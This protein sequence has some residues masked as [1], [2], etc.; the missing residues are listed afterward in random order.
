MWVTNDY[1]LIKFISSNVKELFLYSPEEIY[2]MGKQAWFSRIHPDDREYVEESYNSFVKN[3]SEFNVEYRVRRKDDC[4]IWI[5]DRAV[6]TYELNSFQYRCGFITDI[7]ERKQLEKF[8]RLNESEMRNKEQ[9]F[10]SIIKHSHDGVV[11]LNEEGII[12]EWNPA[13]KNLT[14]ISAYKALGNYFWDIRYLLKPPLDQK[15]TLNRIHHSKKL[16]Q[17][18]LRT[19]ESVLFL[20]P[21]EG[22]ILHPQKGLTYIQSNIFPIKT[23]RGYMLGGIW[24][25]ITKQKNDEDKMKKKLLKFNIEDRSIYLIKEAEPVMARAVFR[26]VLKVGY[27]GIVFSR[28]PETEFR[29]ILTEECKFIWLAEST[30]EDTYVS[31]FQKIISTLHTLSSK[32]VVLIDRLDYLISVYGFEQTLR[33]IYKLREMA[34]IFGFT[35]LISIDEATISEDQIVLLEKETR[36]IRS[37]I[38]ADVPESLLEIL[39]IVYRQTSLGERPSYSQIASE[40]AISRPTTR[41]RLKQ[42]VCT[43]YLREY[44]IGRQKRVELSWKGF[45]YISQ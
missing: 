33:L 21:Q 25:D 37:R 23:D 35:I 15:P 43:G 40:L 8:F 29:K 31:L 28:T 10:R 18:A 7:T 19:G 34:T 5:H 38:L 12:I 24:R 13:M 14:G 17:G 32:C 16:I 30:L 44:K 27:P 42:L 9:E 6:T 20:N 3:E 41:K 4:W 39:R 45:N 22:G 1:G 36:D 26:D 11:L 2:E